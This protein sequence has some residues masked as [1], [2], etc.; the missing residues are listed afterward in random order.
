MLEHT[1]THT[2]THTHARTRAFLVD[3]IDVDISMEWVVRVLS[4][5]SGLGVSMSWAV[6]VFKLTKEFRRYNDLVGFDISTCWVRLGVS[7]Y[8]VVWR[9]NVQG[10]LAVSVGF[11]AFVCVCGLDDRGY[12]SGLGGRGS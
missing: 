4:G 3:C 8:W 7:L 10:G 5:L 11:V 12:L 1:H 9:A 2:H 6:K